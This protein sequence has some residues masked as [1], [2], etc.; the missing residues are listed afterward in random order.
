MSAWVWVMEHPYFA[1]SDREAGAF[2][3]KNVPAGD[4]EVEA[5]HETL[6]TVSAKITVGESDVTQD[7]TLKP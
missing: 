5:W 3:I 1:V 4:Y 6:G 7:F 2:E